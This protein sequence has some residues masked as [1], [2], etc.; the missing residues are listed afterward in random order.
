MDKEKDYAKIQ[1]VFKLK[2]VSLLKVNAEAINSDFQ[3]TAKLKVKWDFSHA[4]DNEQQLL[5]IT[6]ECR[7]LFEPRSICEVMTQYSLEYKLENTNN[8]Q[9]YIES[10]IEELADP[11]GSLNSLIVGQLFD[12]LVDNPLILPPIISIGEKEY[13][14]VKTE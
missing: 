11:C 1:S 6:A 3:G 10:Y 2:D 4:I 12:K 7:V 14:T 9:E 13:G 8:I 5:V